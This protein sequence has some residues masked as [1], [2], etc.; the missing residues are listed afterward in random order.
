MYELV[1]LPDVCII[2]LVVVYVVSVIVRYR[3]FRIRLTI[4]ALNFIECIRVFQIHDMEKMFKVYGT[5]WHTV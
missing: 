4:Y 1:T 3:D 2:D 5:M